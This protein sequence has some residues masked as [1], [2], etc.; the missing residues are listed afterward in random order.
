MVFVSRVKAGLARLEELHPEFGAS[1]ASIGIAECP[2]HGTTV[3][4][5]LAAADAALYA[6]KRGGRNTVVIAER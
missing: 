2:E 3:T 6:A 4:S 1:S 5:V